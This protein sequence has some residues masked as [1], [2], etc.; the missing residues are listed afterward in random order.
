MTALHR[1]V[2]TYTSF[3]EERVLTLVGLD[4]GSSSDVCASQLLSSR[5]SRS[6]SRSPLLTYL[7]GRSKS[8]GSSSMAFRFEAISALSASMLV[9]KKSSSV[10]HV[11]KPSAS[12]RQLT[13]PMTMSE[14]S[15]YILYFNHWI[16]YS[17]FNGSP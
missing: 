9:G 7:L 4:D 8:M 14:S 11:S 13:P 12:T 15:R 17:C 2:R 6:F 10:T 1:R 5:S 3:K 16:F